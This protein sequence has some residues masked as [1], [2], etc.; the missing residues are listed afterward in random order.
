MNANLNVLPIDALRVVGDPK[1]F[2]FQKDFSL[3]PQDCAGLISL[4]E[5]SSA[6]YYTAEMIGKDK[7]ESYNYIRSTNCFIS[8][9]DRPEWAIWDQILFAKLRDA[10]DELSVILPV[11]MEL[12]GSF[13]DTGYQIQRSSPGDFCQWHT[14]GQSETSGSR[15]MICIW[16]LNS[17]FEGGEL[18]FMYQDVSYKPRAGTLTICPATWTHVHQV[19][20][21]TEGERYAIITWLEHK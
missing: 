5:K 17:N 20:E 8:R 16:H 18:E 14:D 6:D 4:F 9:G 21:V 11:G 12:I 2:I 3:S 19:K 10:L 15:F 1:D 7:A 13:E